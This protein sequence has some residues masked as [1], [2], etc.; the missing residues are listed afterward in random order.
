MKPRLLIALLTLVAIVPALAAP[1]LTVRF[2]NPAWTGVAVPPGQQCAKLGG[3]GSTPA[4]NVFDLPQ[5]TGALLLEFNERGGG[6]RG[7]LL[8]S[9]NKGVASAQ[10]PSVQSQGRLPGG[11]S[12]VSAPEGGDG[13][14]LPPCTQGKAYF[15]VVKALEAANPSAPVLGE[16]RLELGKL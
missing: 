2:A 6:S 7:R 3:Q 4:L 16:G 8:F 14:Y 15:L 9:I 12:L 1:R 5:G 11:F 13:N 10:V